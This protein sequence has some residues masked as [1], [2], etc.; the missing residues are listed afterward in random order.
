MDWP[1]A[2]VAIIIIVTIA[3][4]LNKRRNE[5]LGLVEDVHGD[6]VTIPDRGTQQLREDV[7]YLKDRVAVLEKLATE[8]RDAYRLENEIE[9]LRDR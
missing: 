8:D 1:E 5:R 9:K 3:K 7:K 4:F 6:L 2:I